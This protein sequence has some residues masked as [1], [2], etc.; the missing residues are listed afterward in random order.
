MEDLARIEARLES[1]RE[2]GDLVGALR[3]MAASRSQEA[4]E[5]SKGTKA[6][7]AIIEQAIREI[8]PL[9]RSDPWRHGDG[10]R[11]NGDGRRILLAVTSENGFVGGFNTRLIDTVE[12]VRDPDE[13]LLVVG[14]RGQITGDERGIAPDAAFPMT[15]RRD[16][17]T[18]LAQRIARQLAEVEGARLIYARSRGGAAYEVEVRRVLPLDLPVSGNAPASPLD[19]PLHHLAPDELLAGLAGEYLF[20][21]IA[22]ALMESLAAENAARLATMDAASRNIDDRL[23]KLRR[24]ERTAR[25]E[26]TTS[27]MLDVVT[28][29]EAVNHG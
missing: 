28:G 24:E 19:A 6:Y 15:S 14:R 29:A 26:Q 17:V 5:A 27:D 13:R 4:R 21:Q 16:G 20:A 1:L 18:P 7:R 10:R 22:D 12:N 11:E 9:G 2:L 23:D 3:S 25:Q 8:A